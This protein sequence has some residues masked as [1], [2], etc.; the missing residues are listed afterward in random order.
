M[1]KLTMLFAAALLAACNGRTNE[2][3]YTYSVTD[4]GLA[5]R[6]M[7]LQ[8]PFT[9]VELEMAGNASF[10]TEQTV[11]TGLTK[12]GYIKYRNEDIT[13]TAKE[14]DGR[15]AITMQANGKKITASSDTGKETIKEAIKHIKM[16][17]KKVNP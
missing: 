2:S 10:N 11:I 14:T 7:T 6:E 12:G 15:V 4:E 9:D 17:Q 1:K 13:L 5:K 8:S 16:L 3:R